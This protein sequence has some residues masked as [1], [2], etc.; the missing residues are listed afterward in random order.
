MAR[1]QKMRER[2][3]DRQADKIT[4]TGEKKGQKQKDGRGSEKE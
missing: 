3:N 2:V 4:K 1:K